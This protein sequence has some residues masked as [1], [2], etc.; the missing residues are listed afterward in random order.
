MGFSYT[1]TD[2]DEKTA[3]RAGRLVTEHGQVN[4]PVFMPV[5]TQGTVKT[6]AP[7]DLKALGAPMML[8][9]TYHLYLR[10][11]HERIA[12][13]GGLHKFASWD[14]PILTDS[15]GFQVFSLGKLRKIT[16]EGVRFQSHIDG[17]SHLLTPERAIQ[18][19]Q[20]L[21]SDI[22]MAFDEC[23]PYPATEEYARSSMEMTCRWT[24][25]CKEAWTRQELALF[26]IVQGGM[27]PKLREECVDRL[28]ELDLPGYAVGGLSVG[29]SKTMLFEI[30]EATVQLLPKDK[31]R[32]L[33]GVGTPE[34]IVKAI[35]LGFDMF[36]CV[37]PTR[38]ARNGTL[39]TSFGKLNIKNSKCADD[40]EPIDSTCECETC[41][42]YSRAY[43]RHLYHAGEVSVLRL[44]TVHNLHYYFRLIESAQKAIAKKEFMTY[45]RAFIEP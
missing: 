21:G 36:D 14:R 18:I 22:M 30:A 39:F 37:L 34:D 27:F 15:G 24:A 26:G 32:Y 1:V 44:L 20:A 4:T 41:R 3:A 16:E 29:E 35:G 23:T 17:S 19:Q 8:S 2:L 25:R 9:N 31:P 12:E 10:P 11:G 33:M 5:G 13:H 38:N 6:L 7:P 43:L 28:L 45:D 42:N 40:P